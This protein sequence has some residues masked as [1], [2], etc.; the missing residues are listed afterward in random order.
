MSHSNA[1]VDRNTET[2]EPAFKRRRIEP[3]PL[4][5]SARLAA[6][7]CT[8][9]SQ[10]PAPSP[11]RRPAPPALPRMTTR[12]MTA[13]QHPMTTRNQYRS[14]LNRIHEVLASYLA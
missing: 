14:A 3:E 10:A 13:R 11:V 7:R 12:S 9:P 6:K 1:N 5:R 4:R 8:S 2:G